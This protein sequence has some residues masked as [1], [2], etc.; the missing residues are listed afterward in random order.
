M[1]DKIVNEGVEDSGESFVKDHGFAAIPIHFNPKEGAE[2]LIA[3]VIPGI[4]PPLAFFRLSGATPDSLTFEEIDGHV[5][6][7]SQADVG[8]EIKDGVDKEDTEQEDLTDDAE[9]METE[10]ETESEPEGDDKTVEYP[11]EDAAGQPVAGFL[12]G[13]EDVLPLVV[14]VIPQDGESVDEAMA[15][16]SS[17]H[18]EHI[19][20]TLDEAIKI[21]GHSPLTSEDN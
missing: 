4:E 10:S 14:L 5:D 19:P 6:S 9:E 18:P 12:L 3:L 15:R 8:E 2:K 11:H 1:K 7:V 21:L 17:D 20:G 16:V 13:N